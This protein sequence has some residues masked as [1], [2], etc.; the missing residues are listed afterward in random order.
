M[1]AAKPLSVAMLTRR[2]NDRLGDFG[3][4]VV[5][6]ELSQVRVVA[7][8][9]CYA[10]LK[11]RDASI[12]LVMWR[13][14][15]ARHGPLPA[16]GTA[17]LV[18][19]SLSVYAPRGSYQLVARSIVAEGVGDLAA[20]FEALRQQ[21]TGEGLFNDEHKQELPLLPSA[22]GIATAAGSA[23]LADMLHGV[24]DR[25]STMPVIHAPCRVQ[26][27]GAAEE[28]A[29]A[30]HQLDAHPEVGVIVAG[31]GGGSL[32]DLW[33]FNEEVVVRAIYACRTPI[34][35]A[36]GHESDTTLADLVAD[37]RAKTPTAAIELA[38]PD[39]DELLAQ[40][41]AL[42]DD[43]DERIGYRVERARSRLAAL[44]AH[45]A[46]ADPAHQVAMRI[47]RCDDL[48]GRL[49]RLIQHRISER[50]ELLRANE[51][52]LSLLD[53]RRQLPQQ[54]ARLHDLARELDHAIAN[55]RHSHEQRL[56]A[57]AGQLHALSPLAVLGRGYSVVHNEHGAVIS[58][59][60]DAPAG[61][62]IRT[63]LSDGWLNA[64]V[65][66]SEALDE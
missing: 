8:G 39:H 56:A 30:I 44:S 10:T 5:R 19:G 54:Q 24:E 6:G 62:S 60:A 16:E 13:S 28:I 31:R 47:Q 14:S 66:A 41:D 22:L 4:L 45:R 12:S 1:T 15:V 29:A 9:H 57:G 52:A 42:R 55:L 35:S 63:R 37:V 46:L 33:A 58:H 25:F 53:P 7:S 17:V 36:V 43:L 65:S 3:S 32:E 2:I 49:D 38:L 40:L 50:R 20:R 61:S 18:H 51:H 11:D 64:T 59:I 21:L 26:G 34:I 23:A 48:Q 27:N